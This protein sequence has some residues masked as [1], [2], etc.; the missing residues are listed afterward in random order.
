MVSLA[1]DHML[2]G[3]LRYPPPIADRADDFVHRVLGVPL[4]LPTSRFL[5]AGALMGTAEA[6]RWAARVLATL[7]AHWPAHNS[8]ALGGG[9]RDTPEFPRKH[10][11]K[12][13]D[14]EI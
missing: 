9:M 8:L 3:I 10:T 5:N 12:H 11:K 13:H 2:S 7:L 14:Q 6:P 1:K 4:P